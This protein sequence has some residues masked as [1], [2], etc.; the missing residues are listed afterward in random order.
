MTDARSR[1]GIT[2]LLAASLLFEFSMSGE[3]VVLLSF[4]FINLE[5]EPFTTVLRVFMEADWDW[6]KDETELFRVFCCWV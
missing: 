1:E 5:L 4:G 2:V 3:V 6:L